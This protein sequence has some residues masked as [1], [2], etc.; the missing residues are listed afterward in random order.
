MKARHVLTGSTFEIQ[1]SDKECSELRSIYPDSVSAAHALE[2]LIKR[3]LIM[4][5]ANTGE[6]EENERM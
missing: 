6:D 2:S 1:L 3:A 5:P 4:S